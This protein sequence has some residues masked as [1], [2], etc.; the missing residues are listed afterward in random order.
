[1]RRNTKTRSD[2][3]SRFTGVYYDSR[4]D[5]YQASIKGD[6][7][8]VSLGVHPSELEAAIAVNVA[9][10]KLGVAPPN[11]LTPT[12]KHE[13]NR[14]RILRRAQLLAANRKKQKRIP[15]IKG[16][17]GPEYKIQQKIIRF[18]EAR[19]WYVK[20]MTGTMY[21]WGIPDLYACHKRHGHKWIE[22]KNP[23][24]YSFTAAQHSEFP[25]FQAH[26]D[27]IYIL[28]AANEANYK[29]LFAPTDNLW[30]YMSGI[31]ED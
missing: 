14:E 25:K 12:E 3:V 10:E 11:K 30:E 31:A 2:S 21:Q 24:S 17:K 13:V 5:T 18:L 28:T 27:P 19:G 22:V 8:K 16:V 23:E 9:A 4:Y 15:K 7:G 1:M 29:R 26:G 6:A 20:V